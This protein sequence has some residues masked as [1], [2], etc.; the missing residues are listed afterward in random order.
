MQ[1]LIQQVGVGTGI[2]HLNKHPGDTA[3][4]GLQNTLWVTES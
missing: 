1:I 4:A 2:L 3:D